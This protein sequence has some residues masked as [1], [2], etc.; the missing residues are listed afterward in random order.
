M[1]KLSFWAVF[2]IIYLILNEEMQHLLRVALMTT[3]LLYGVCDSSSPY[4]GSA[5]FISHISL[6]ALV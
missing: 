4:V 2:A 3:V 5:L 1:K 6:N